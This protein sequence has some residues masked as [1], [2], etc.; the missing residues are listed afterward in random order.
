MS[1]S[2]PVAKMNNQLLRALTEVAPTRL[3]KGSRDERVL[4]VPY[5]KAPGLIGALRFDWAS[6]ESKTIPKTTRRDPIA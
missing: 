1:G 2:N 6:P 5:W 4:K 3:N